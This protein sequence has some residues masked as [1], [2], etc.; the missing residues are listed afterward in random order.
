M[1]I[2][3]TPEGKYQIVKDILD[4]THTEEPTFGGVPVTKYKYKVVPV[5]EKLFL[6]EVAAVDW[7]HYLNGGVDC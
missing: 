2:I 3:Q 4:Y 5:L 1:R 6:S 7:I